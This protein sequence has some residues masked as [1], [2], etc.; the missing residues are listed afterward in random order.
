[1]AAMRLY[2]PKVFGGRTNDTWMKESEEKLAKAL[3]ERLAPVLKVTDGN[4]E[5]AEPAGKAISK[6]LLDWAKKELNVLK[7]LKAARK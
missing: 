5:K 6:E 3:V 4:P 7:A 1:M 2:S